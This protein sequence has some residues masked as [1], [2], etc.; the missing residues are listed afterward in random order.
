[1]DGGEMEKVIPGFSL[2]TSSFFDAR[3]VCRFPVP[4]PAVVQ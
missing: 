3:H 1:M 4:L 2:L